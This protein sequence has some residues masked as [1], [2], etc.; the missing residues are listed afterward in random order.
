MD[1]PLP[2]RR[3]ILTSM[4]AYTRARS[5]ALTLSH[6]DAIGVERAPPGHRRPPSASWISPWGSSAALAGSSPR[7]FQGGWTAHTTPSGDL[8]AYTTS[9]HGGQTNPESIIGPANA[10]PENA[11]TRCYAERRHPFDEPAADTDITTAL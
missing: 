8:A 11:A 3:A 2:L 5:C 10:D 1:F 4:R 7:A 9:R 6:G